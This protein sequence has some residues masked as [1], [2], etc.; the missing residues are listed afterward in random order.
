M[1]QRSEADHTKAVFCRLEHRFRA[2]VLMCWL[3]LLL[4]RV[5]GSRAGMTW[6]R[7]DTELGRVHTAPLTTAQTGILRD[8]Q[9]APIAH[10]HCGNCQDL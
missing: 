9:V 3:A 1:K 8:C 10:D 4:V 6:R 5:V 2:H 7:I